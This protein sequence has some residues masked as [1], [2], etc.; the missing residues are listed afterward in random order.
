M[1]LNPFSVKPSPPAVSTSRTSRAGVTIDD[2]PL[3]AGVHAHSATQRSGIGASVASHFTT[4]LKGTPGFLV[5]AEL[6]ATWS[7]AHP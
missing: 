3:T 7:W 5:R 1:N 2:E 6:A 4:C